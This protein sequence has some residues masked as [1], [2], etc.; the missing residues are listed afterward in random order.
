MTLYPQLGG[1]CS[2][3]ERLHVKLLMGCI[4]YRLGDVFSALTAKKEHVPH[5][6]SKLTQLLADSLGMSVCSPVC[7]DQ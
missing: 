2:K 3:P 5:G 7:K 6:N 1:E 4:V